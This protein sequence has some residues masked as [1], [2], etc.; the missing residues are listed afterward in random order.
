MGTTTP[1]PILS[2]L[3][4]IRRRREQPPRIVQL[5]PSK[6][7]SLSPFVRAVREKRLAPKTFCGGSYLPDGRH[8]A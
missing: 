3:E 2:R 5:Y 8:A 4:A 6:P 1:T 7:T